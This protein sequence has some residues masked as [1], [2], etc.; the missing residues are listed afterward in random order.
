MTTTF[1]FVAGAVCLVLGYWFHLHS[2]PDFLKP[3]ID[4]FIAHLSYFFVGLG[5]C[6][7]AHTRGIILGEYTASARKNK[8]F[9]QAW[10]IPLIGAQVAI[11]YFVGIYAILIGIGKAHPVQNL[12]GMIALLIF[13]LLYLL[14]YV[15]ALFYHNFPSLAGLRTSLL[16]LTL[17][18]FSWGCWL[19]QWPIFSLMLAL[20]ALITV[21]VSLALP[22]QVAEQRG[23]WSRLV[24]LLF[25]MVFIAFVCFNAWPFGM[26]RVDL[27]ELSLATND[28]DLRGDMGP[29][30]YSSNGKKI[31][32]SIKEDG[33]YQLE[34][35]SPESKDMRTFKVPVGDTPVLPVFIKQGVDEDWNDIECALIDPAQGESRG[36][37]KVNANNG[38]VAVLKAGGVE[39]FANKLCWSQKTGEL[40]YVT[41]KDGGYLLNAMTVATGKS[42][43]LYHSAHP[44]QAPAWTFS[45]QVAFTDGTHG[46]PYLLDLRSKKALPIMSDDERNEEA[47]KLLSQP[48][49]E[50]VVPSPDGFRYLYVVKKDKTTELW[51][52]LSD[53][54]KREKLYQTRGTV[55]DITWLPDAQRIVFCERSSRLGFVFGSESTK[56]MDANPA[57]NDPNYGV[58]EDLV[59]PLFTSKAPAVSPDGVKVAF[60][61]GKGLWYPSFGNGIWVAVLR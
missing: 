1:F 30:A 59:L 31:G 3:M 10:K 51:T 54:T 40:L 17:A 32:F 57:S 53:G 49:P 11:L 55:R 48:A 5:F 36:I 13:F 18:V 50:E 34:V 9:P 6:L 61:S 52:V 45:G 19:N 25:S 26:P 22:G 7:L 37:W 46:L 35:I 24:I 56:I 2:L 28:W 14:W 42:S 8:Q 58:P 47:D 44:I 16:A 15:I 38:S 27:V 60:V 39:P 21:C 33:N 12:M 43:A 20:F 29:M 41:K 4:P 23:Q